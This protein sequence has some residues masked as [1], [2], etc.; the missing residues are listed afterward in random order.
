MSQS[1]DVIVIGLGAMGSAA[2]YQLSKRKTRVLGIDQFTPPH[3][4]GSSHGD[5]RITRQAIGEGSDYVP[6]VL[7]SHEIWRELENQTGET[8]LTLTGGLIFADKH[9]PTSHHSSDDFLAETIATAQRYNIDHQVLDTK[10]LIQRFPQFNYSGNEIGYFEKGAGLIRPE[11]CVACQ[12][13]LAAQMGAVIQTQETVNAI[14]VN[15]TTNNVT[16]RTTQ[17][18]YEAN[19]V[20][21]TVGAWISTFLPDFYTEIF[22]VYRQVQYWFE[23]EGSIELFS[24]QNCPIYIRLLAGDEVIYGFPALDGDQGGIKVATEQYAVRCSLEQMQRNVSDDEI[25]KMYAYTS[26]YLPISN[27]C[28]KAISCLYTVTPDRHFV[29]DSHPLHPQIILASPCSGHGFKHS[30]A[31]GE[32]LADLALTGQTHFDISRFSLA[33]FR[34]TVHR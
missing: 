16:V 3:S 34:S 32:V 20:I 9:K 15:S 23:V 14:E 31:I 28:V 1:F 5:T 27:T 30:A 18:D 4:Q 25:K 7:R 24:P 6:L 21:L 8:L 12:L 11:N 33:R 26:K 2:L 10:D 22:Q 29:I 19:N 13:K 17:G